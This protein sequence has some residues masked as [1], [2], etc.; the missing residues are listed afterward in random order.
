MQSR[1]GAAEL[2]AD[3]GADHRFPFGR[4]GL[5]VGRAHP[6]VFGFTAALGVITAWLLVKAAVSACPLCPWRASG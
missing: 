2:E 1:P 6:F 5:P 3:A 4:P